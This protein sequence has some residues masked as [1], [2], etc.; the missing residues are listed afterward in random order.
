MRLPMR[1][2]RRINLGIAVIRVRSVGKREMREVA[3]CGPQD[4]NPPTPRLPHAYP[5][6]TR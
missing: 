2:P 4:A 6:P 3:E 5:T 1:L